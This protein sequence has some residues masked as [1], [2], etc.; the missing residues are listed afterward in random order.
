MWRLR[1][2]REKHLHCGVPGGLRRPGS[3][4]RILGVG[5][6]GTSVLL[7]EDVILGDGV[8]VLLQTL[9]SVVTAVLGSDGEAG[10][11]GE[12]AGHYEGEGERKRRRVHGA[13]A[14]HGLA[15]DDVVE[16]RARRQ[17][18]RPQQEAHQQAVGASGGRCLGAEQSLVAYLLGHTA[19]AAAA[20][21]TAV[22]LW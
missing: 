11:E 4:G 6:V 12:E 5:V 10:E 2:Q 16:D 19:A 7:V 17:H 3:Y 21:R 18:E 20:G 14:T 1:V 8:Q 13:G 22:L 9:V 15:E